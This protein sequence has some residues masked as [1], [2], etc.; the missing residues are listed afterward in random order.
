MAKVVLLT[1]LMIL[2]CN[3]TAQ[4]KMQDDWVCLEAV[5]HAFRFASQPDAK[6]V[7]AGAWYLIRR[8]DLDNTQTYVALTVFHAVQQVSWNIADN[9]NI[10]R[11]NEEQFWVGALNKANVECEYMLNELRWGT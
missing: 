3:V 4:N 7:H 1:L 2:S 9:P 10:T 6:T 11:D 5:A 8:T